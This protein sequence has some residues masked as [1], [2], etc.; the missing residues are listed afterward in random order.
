MSVL[1]SKRKY[2]KKHLMI[3]LNI[4]AMSSREKRGKGLVFP[5]DL[6]KTLKLA[7]RLP[8]PL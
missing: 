1:R 7:P 5:R 2:A 3:T 4:E 8:Q 6:S